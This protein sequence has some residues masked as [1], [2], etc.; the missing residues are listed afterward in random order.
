MRSLHFPVQCSIWASGT[1]FPRPPRRTDAS[2]TTSLS[3]RRGTDGCR[4][5]SSRTCLYSPRHL[6]G[7][8]P[9]GPTCTRDHT[10]NP[11]FH[12]TPRRRRHGTRPC[13]FTLN[14]EVPC[15]QSNGKTTVLCGC[16]GVP[17]PLVLRPRHSPQVW[18]L[19]C[20]SWSQSLRQF[21]LELPP[22]LPPFRQGGCAKSGL[23]A[24]PTSH[25]QPRGQ[26][27]ACL[28]LGSISSS[29]DPQA[30]DAQKATRPPPL[31][32]SHSP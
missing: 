4:K 8:L 23:W 31:R 29:P 6:A 28:P 13:E 32:N 17:R 2:V 5:T 10:G 19:P 26:A 9:D 25:S 12:V 3:R 14:I 7:C 30:P 16:Q 18:N 22:R 11:A 24:K 1:R 21:G 27:R 20:E 15:P